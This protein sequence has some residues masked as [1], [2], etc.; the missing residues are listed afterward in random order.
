MAHTEWP[1]R[2]SA[3]LFGP[4]IIETGEFGLFLSNFNW[5]AK[6]NASTPDGL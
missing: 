5:K 1:S 6:I 2:N 3:I 4:G